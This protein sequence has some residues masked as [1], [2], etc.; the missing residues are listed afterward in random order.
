MLDNIHDTLAAWV[1]EAEA[2]EKRFG[3]SGPDPEPAP[4]SGARRGELQAV[5]EKLRGLESLAERAGQVIRTNDGALSEE[6]T[7][8]RRYLESVAALRQRLAA[9]AGRAIG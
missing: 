7:K 4:S 1:E 6:E 9:W 5:Q 8:P 2:R 3:A